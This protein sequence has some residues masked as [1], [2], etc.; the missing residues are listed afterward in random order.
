M[1]NARSGSDR[2]LSRP[3]DA[4]STQVFSML[5][6]SFIHATRSA[7]PIAVAAARM[8]AAAVPAGELRALLPFAAN[9]PGNRFA[10]C[11]RQP[12]AACRPARRPARRACPGALPAAAHALAALPRRRPSAPHFTARGPPNRRRRVSCSRRRGPRLRHGRAH[13]QGHVHQVRRP[14]E[15]QG[16]ARR[17]QCVACGGGSGARSAAAARSFTEVVQGRHR[18]RCALVLLCT[19]SLAASLRHCRR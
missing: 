4:A 8:S 18:S 5:A 11:G 17:Q 1:R 3:D 6:R 10:A 19:A 9:P 12:A 15:G 13:H 16:D 7:R 14:R 2:H